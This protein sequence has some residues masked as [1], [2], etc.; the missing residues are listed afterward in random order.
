MLTRFSLARAAVTGR[1]SGRRIE[2]YE[3]A[4][5][6]AILAFPALL[7]LWRRSLGVTFFALSNDDFHRTLYAWEVTQG[8]LVPS[9]LWPPLQFWVEALALLAYPHILSVPHLVN[10]AASTGALVAL[11]LLGRALRLGAAARLLLLTL[12]ATLPWF[13]WVSLS[14]LGEPLFLL[15]I[16]AGYAGVAWWRG[17]GAPRALWVAAAG[18]AGAGMV[19]FDAWGHALPFSLGVAWLWWRSAA[20]P[21]SWLAA[22]ALPWLFPAAWLG[23]QQVAHGRPLYFA[24]VVRGIWLDTY[25][26]LSLQLR[27]RWQPLDLWLLAGVTLPLALAGL[28]LMW[29]RPGVPLMAFMWLASFALLMQST[30]SHAIALHNQQRLVLAH[31]LLLTPGAALALSRFARC[32]RAAPLAALALLLA[33]A[34]GRLA[35][36]P[37]YPNGL[38]LDVQLVGSHVDALRTSGVLRPGD[39]I[40]IEVIFWDYVSLHLLMNDPGAVEYD[41]APR[42]IIRERKYTMDDITNPS[43]LALPP[44]ELRPELRRRGVRVVVAHS[45]RAAANLRPIARQT[46]HAG[47]FRVFVIE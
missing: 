39:R 23:W 46:E 26:P 1:S 11:V 21:P 9:D 38:A 42:P 29:R 25:G 43:L 27:L 16:S 19:R 31:T 47:R 8:R 12:A 13:I 30:L 24:E 17:H 34:V 35:A 18:F 10:L 37:A 6:L 2:A 22:A 5:A 36:V 3:L 41:R 44:D 40:V 15:G 14:G 20:R 7:L 28:L 32:G 33:L 4:G 45:E